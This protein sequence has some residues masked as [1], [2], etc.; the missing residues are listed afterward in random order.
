M[1]GRLKKD[2]C[3]SMSHIVCIRGLR[4]GYAQAEKCSYDLRKTARMRHTMVKTRKAV[5]RRL[6]RAG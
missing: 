6:M 3:N 2:P 4:A 1:V 5:F